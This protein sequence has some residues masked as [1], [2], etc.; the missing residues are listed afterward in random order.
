M[1]LYRSSSTPEI[2]E[3][4]SMESII[5]DP[6]SIIRSLHKDNAKDLAESSL[7][8]KYFEEALKDDM[9]KVPL[10]HQAS[11][12]FIKPGSLV[13]FQAMVQDMFDPEFYLGKYVAMN[14]VTKAKQTYYGSY[15]DIDHSLYSEEIDFDSPSN[16]TME[17]Q[18]LRCIPIPGLNSWVKKYH[19]ENMKEL[20]LSTVSSVV[21]PGKKRRLG[22]VDE[23]MEEEKSVTSEMDSGDTLT[24][25]LKSES[26][27]EGQPTSNVSQSKTQQYS[28]NFPLPN[29]DGLACLVKMY[30][31]M[32]ELKLNEMVEFVGVYSID[33]ALATFTMGETTTTD[34]EMVSWPSA[35]QNQQETA[36]HNPPTSVVPRIHCLFHRVLPYVNPLLPAI[37]ESEVYTDFVSSL[38]SDIVSIRSEILQLL[39]KLLHGDVVAAEFLLLSLISRV[40]G[41]CGALAIGKLPINLFKCSKEDARRVAGVVERMVEKSFFLPMT[42]DNLNK[43][44]YVPKKDYEANILQSGVLQLSKGTILML[45]ETSMEAGTLNADGVENL[46]AIGNVIQWQKVDYNFQFHRM[47]NETDIVCIM[48]SEGESL[49][50]CDLKI[51]ITKDETKQN[52]DDLDTI[53]STVSDE[54]WAKIRAYI[55]VVSSME[56]SLTEECQKALQDDFVEMRKEDA[57]SANA[58]SFYLL[59][60]IARYLTLS[61]GQ[62]SLPSPLWMKTKEL[63]GIRQARLAKKT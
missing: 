33:P 46:K 59:L 56:Y 23:P 39:T 28:S 57:K 31:N 38:K 53:L 3:T 35:G 62:E 4:K 60:T 27:L 11:K 50:K 30:H 10:L 47:E 21:S 61:Y 6:L 14:T 42:I 41:R 51:P 54:F 17:R 20:N 26:A 16:V 34:E 9:N 48:L 36:A 22:E 44:K 19:L 43:M 52:A 32:G 15:Q 49:L 25:K 1:K 40:Y 63:D 13:R 29:E 7:I 55:S 5:N 18:T 58:D 8:S 2:I 24:K 37:K 12:D 45:D